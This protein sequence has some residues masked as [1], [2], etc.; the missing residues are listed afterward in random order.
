MSQT[1][2][3]YKWMEDCYFITLT[4]DGE[5]LFVEYYDQAADFGECDAYYGSW[6]MFLASTDGKQFMRAEL[7]GD[8]RHRKFQRVANDAAPVSF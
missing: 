6:P 1:V 7:D 2:S 3:T 4:D 5:H 8:V